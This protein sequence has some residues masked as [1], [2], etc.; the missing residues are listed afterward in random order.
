MWGERL[1]KDGL[2]EHEVKTD[3]KQRQIFQY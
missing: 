1:A 2:A 3:G